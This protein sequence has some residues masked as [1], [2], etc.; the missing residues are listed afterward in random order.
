M[1]TGP[2][3]LFPFESKNEMINATI[4]VELSLIGYGPE[5]H[6]TDKRG[7]SGY[8]LPSVAAALSIFLCPDPLPAL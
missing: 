4:L 5:N 1:L 7:I 6:E 2:F 3:G 8:V